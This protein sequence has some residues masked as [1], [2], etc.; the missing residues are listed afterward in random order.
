MKQIEEL[1]AD[2]TYIVETSEFIPSI[3]EVKEA[4]TFSTYNILYVPVGTVM[5]VYSLS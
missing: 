3:Y 4:N 5:T 1:E 2:D